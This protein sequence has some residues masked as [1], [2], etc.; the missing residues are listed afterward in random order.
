MLGS[1]LR[2]QTFDT[3]E[4]TNLRVKE[5]LEAGEPEGLVVRAFAQTGG[6]GRQGRHWQSP[7]GGL[8]CSWLL[9]PTQHPSALSTLS[10]VAAL[11]VR[12]A[13]VHLLDDVNRAYSSIIRIK[14][15]NDVVFEKPSR[16]EKL[17]GIS[18]EQHAG[19]LCL[20]IGINVFRPQKQLPV[21][22]IIIPA[23][24]E[25]FTDCFQ[26]SSHREG[27]NQVFD[28]LCFELAQA[29]HLWSAEGFT[30][31]VQ[32]Y[33]AHSLLEGKEIA[34][35]NLQGKVT[36]QGVVQGIDDRGCLLLQTPSGLQAINSGEAHL[37][38]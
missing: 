19:G 31:F 12:S 28:A 21:E 13:L 32:E 18:L 38:L 29:Y 30:P 33:Q 26:T 5:A 15:P 34:V 6:Y 7:E 1:Q 14:W 24:L 11:A 35:K 22:G 3:V 8:Y 36:A 27:L 25:D 4:S 20:G 23:Y 10:L 17:C 37:A 2:I 16:I 9:R